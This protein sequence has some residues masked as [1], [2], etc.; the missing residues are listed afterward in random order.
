MQTINQCFKQLEK[1]LETKG[2][3]LVIFFYTQDDIKIKIKS[4]INDKFPNSESEELNIEN[5]TYQDIS[6]SL[7]KK[8]NIVFIDSFDTVLEKK[9]LFLGF[10]QRRDKISS[11]NVRIIA[12]VRL[13]FICNGI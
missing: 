4:F 2:F 11:Y 10:N 3:R 9:E 7:Y 5:K 12:F 1:L 6:K 8:D 13:Y